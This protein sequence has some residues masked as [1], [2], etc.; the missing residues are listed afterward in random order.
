MGTV[1]RSASWAATHRLLGECDVIVVVAEELQDASNIQGLAFLD[2]RGG[3]PL[4]LCT[5][6]GTENLRRLARVRVDELVILDAEEAELPRIVEQLWAS[7]WYRALG[8][9]LDG[10]LRDSPI[11]ARAVQ[12]AFEQRPPVPGEVRRRRA[13]GQP[14]FVRNVRDAAAWMGCH[15]DY[16]T[17]T[18]RAK[19]FPLSDV[20][21]WVT[22]LQG[23]V[24][25]RPPWTRWHEIATRLGFRDPSAWTHFVRRLTGMTPS[26]FACLAPEEIV[27]RFEREVEG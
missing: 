9:R 6:G 23:V 3:R 24:L 26:E 25:Y 21:R 5:G 14:V 15:P 2:D 11:L 7:N 22:V 8:S 17:R 18:A 12:L 10:Q 20:L 13:Q 16:L 1:R 19:G 27:A 4:V